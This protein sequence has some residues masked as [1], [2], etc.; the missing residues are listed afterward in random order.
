MDDVMNDVNEDNLFAQTVGEMTILALLFAN[1][2]AIS[3][4]TI[5]E[6]KKR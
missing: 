4:F 3:S 2:L 6:L 5:D 1:Y